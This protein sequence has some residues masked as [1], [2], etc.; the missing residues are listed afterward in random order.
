[1]SS[2][3]DVQKDEVGLSSTEVAALFDPYTPWGPSDVGLAADGARTGVRIVKHALANLHGEPLIEAI[4]ELRTGGESW[5]LVTKEDFGRGLPA[6][7]LTHLSETLRKQR[8]VCV[9]SAGI[10]DPNVD[11]C[12]KEHGVMSLKFGS[13]SDYDSITEVQRLMIRN[14]SDFFSGK[15]GEGQL[16]NQTIMV[17][18]LPAPGK[19]VC[20]TVYH[21]LTLEHLRWLRAGSRVK[22]GVKDK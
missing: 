15:S 1:M 2:T 16:I 3:T 9:I 14:M 22:A 19:F 11:L 8:C 5:V 20:K 17:Q 6:E 18:V 4:T 10:I 21:T 12:L 13:E 7:G